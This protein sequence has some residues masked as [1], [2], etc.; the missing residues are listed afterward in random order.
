[1]LVVASDKFGTI[2][3]TFLTIEAIQMRRHTIAGI[4]LSQSAPEVD[5]R[6][7]NARDPERRLMA[8]VTRL[9][10]CP[11]REYNSPSQQE[12]Q[13][14]SPLIDGCLAGTTTAQPLQRT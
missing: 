4:A 5:S 1:M 11:T 14:L 10:H 6:M 3:H 7:N 12:L 8:S 13:A 9:P 2:N